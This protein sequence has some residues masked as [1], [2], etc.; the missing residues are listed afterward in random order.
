M[1]IDVLTLFPEL[2]ELVV[3]QGMPRW[4]VEQGALRLN[5]RQ[6]RDYS[7][8]RGR[9]VDDRP[10]GGGPGMVMEPEPLAQAMEA[11]RREAQERGGATKVV[12]MSPQGEELTQPWLRC[13]AE[14]PNLVLLCGRYEGID[15]RIAQQVDLELSIG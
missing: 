13:F 8:D 3:R 12:L 7:T 15:E 14:E 2:V 11:A 9:R 6:I 5:L 10:Y 1:Q 4:S